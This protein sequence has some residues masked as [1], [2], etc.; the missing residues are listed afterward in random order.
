MNCVFAHVMKVVKLH[1]RSEEPFPVDHAVGSVVI[2][3]GF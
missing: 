1:T 3:S 2:C